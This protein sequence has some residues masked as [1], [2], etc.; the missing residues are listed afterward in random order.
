MK[1]TTSI[2][3][4]LFAGCFNYLL[5]Q[6]KDIDSLKLVLN[7]RKGKSDTKQVDL[8]NQIA[9]LFE[10]IDAKQTRDYCEQALTIARK[11]DY[12][13]GIS[14]S[15]HVIGNSYY[16]TGDYKDA[17]KYYLASV[18]IADAIN[19]KRGVTRT[20]K[21]LGVCFYR[22]KD[23]DKALEYYNNALKFATELKETSLISGIYN[24]IGVVLSEQ[25]KFAKARETYFKALEGYKEIGIKR[26]ESIALSNIGD[27]YESE[28]SY[29]KALEYYQQSLKIDRELKKDPYGMAITLRSIGSVHI[30]MRNFDKVEKVLLEALK[31][32]K[33]LGSKDTEQE[34]YDTYSEFYEAK[35]DHENALKYYKKHVALKDSIFDTD[36]SGQIA[37]MQTKYETAKKDKELALQQK[38]IAEKDKEISDNRVRQRTILIG[39]LLL[40]SAAFFI[41]SRQ[42][43]RNR[44]NKEI[45]ET[46]EK[47]IQEQ[48]KNAE[49]DLK[50]KNKELTTYA[51]HI[52]QKN[53]I[54]TEL[55]DS[56]QEAV[57]EMSRE[58][59]KRLNKLIHLINYSFNLD[60]DWKDFKIAFEQVHEGFFEK[61]QK[62]YPTISPSEIRLCA[63]L[64]L[65]FASKEIAAIMGISPDSVKVARYRLRKKL[66]LSRNDSLVD[67]IRNI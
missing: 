25:K 53:N 60:R 43:L 1:Y 9:K 24:N 5:A 23:F 56:I 50:F 12:K 42:R 48:L 44:K 38:S 6:N 4:F 19:D 47:L 2:I 11:I 63:L 55:K 51:L 13:A 17:I 59:S 36:K 61:L 52:I 21:N 58:E 46:N 18:K 66:E 16:F 29:E 54:L 39:M 34:V 27:T 62:H 8:L 33:D 20:Y 64:R 65:N 22:T 40:V 41:V 14:R 35:N 28:K 31:I 15:N 45:F 37:E 7:E 10:R 32:A 26:R 3:F 30:K 57:G 49:Q 67:F